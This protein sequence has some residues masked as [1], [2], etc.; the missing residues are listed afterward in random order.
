M[1]I[2]KRFASPIKQVSRV[3]R[4]RD[5]DE[6]RPVCQDSPALVMQRM[7]SSNSELEAPTTIGH[8]L[9]T[10]MIG[11]QLLESDYLVHEFPTG[12]DEA[13]ENCSKTVNTAL[14]ARIEMLN[15]ENDKLKSQQKYFRLEC[16]HHD[17]NLVC[18]YT[19]FISYAIFVAFFDFLGP[20]V[21]QLH[22][23]GSREGDRVR[24]Y[25]RKLD[26][27]NQLF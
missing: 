8:Q 14:L 11:E 3:K 12:S 16:I 25:N 17:D 19:S 13:T 5:R 10:V 20:V 27:K 9:H 7:E 21:T 1:L 18:F 15:A 6:M 22:Y 23:W 24:N 26:P 4:A 2:G